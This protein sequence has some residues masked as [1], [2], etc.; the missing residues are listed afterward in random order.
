LVSV[1]ESLASSLMAVSA[2]DCVR[3]PLAFKA[4]K[5]V[6][7]MALEPATTSSAILA[8]KFGAKYLLFSVLGSST[9]SPGTMLRLMFQLK[10]RDTG[11]A[12]AGSGL[13]DYGGVVDQRLNGAAGGRRQDAQSQIIV[14]E[15]ASCV[16][17][18]GGVGEATVRQASEK[19]RGIAFTRAARWRR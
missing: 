9:L 4:A 8:A 17:A 6:Q 10:D 14:T 2:P 1:T 12:T 3:S 19:G 7:S 5:L 13:L 15:P 16:T 11:L 18:S